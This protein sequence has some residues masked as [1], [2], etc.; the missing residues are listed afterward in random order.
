VFCLLPDIVVGEY[1]KI[2]LI[3]K[4]AIQ[5][6][7]NLRYIAIRFLGVKGINIE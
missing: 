3:G 7:D 2:N 5:S 6:A 4:P 1:I